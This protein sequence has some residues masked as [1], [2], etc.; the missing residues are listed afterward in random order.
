MSSIPIDRIAVNQ[1]SFSNTRV[2]YSGSNII[3]LN[4]RTRS[5]QLTAKRYVV[6]FTSLTTRGMHLE[7]ATDMTTDAFI[8]VLCKFI[9]RRGHVKILRS[10]NGSYP[11][12]GH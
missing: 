9:A 3:K 1:K 8:L 12:N 4:K 6:F 10:D 5:T 7:L 11:E 2:D